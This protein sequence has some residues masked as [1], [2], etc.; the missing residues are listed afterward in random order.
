MAGANKTERPVREAGF[1]RIGGIDQWVAIHGKSRAN[2]VLVVLHG[3]PGSPETLFFRAFNIALEAAYT[4]VYWDQRGAGRSYNKSIP[5]DSMTVD[6]FVAD[7][8]ELVDSLRAEFAV[9]RVV[10]LGH[11]W[12]SMLGVLYAARFPDK[13][14]AFVGVGQVADMTASEK[15]SYDFAL[16]WAEKAGRTKAVRALKAIG[17]PPHRLAYIR[18]Q[19]RW[20]AAAG[21]VVGPG[22]TLPNLIWRALTGPGATPMDLVR[23]SRGAVFSITHLWSELAAT[24]LRRDL[25]KVPVPIFFVLGRLDMQVV[26][27]VAADWFDKI[28][29]P[30]KTLIWLEKSAHM[31]PFEE[32][33]A[34][35]RI[36]IDQVRPLA[37]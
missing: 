24:N 36:M 6:Q 27:S 35:N 28:E 25:R 23:M 18:T 5:P 21:G 32:P 8:D 22:V 10:I 29:A 34:F 7:L 11:S 1:R 37:V 20:L 15:A 9:P 17:P 12:G 16:A 30:G 31:A 13:V 2:P 4:V 19:R 14:F 33:E 3:G 26:A